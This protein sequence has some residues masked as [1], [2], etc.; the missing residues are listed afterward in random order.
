[1][2]FILLLRIVGADYKAILTQHFLLAAA[3][4]LGLII[5]TSIVTLTILLRLVVKEGQTLKINVKQST[6]ISNKYLEY[7]VAYIFPFLGV[8]L[9]DP[10]TL[11]S[12]GVLFFTIG[13]LYIEA[14]LFYFN[15]ML[16]AFHYD[17]FIAKDQ[18]DNEYILLTKGTIILNNIEVQ[19]KTITGN[20]FV[21]VNS[22][23]M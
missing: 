12:L 5:I 23:N 16:K 13:F 6:D 20:L 10:W 21:I 22:R 18:D 7:I 11:V 4:I 1:L 19:L 8:N 14:E 2:W 3:I 15:P 17:V 9:T